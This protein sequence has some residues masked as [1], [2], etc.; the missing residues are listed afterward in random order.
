MSTYEEAAKIEFFNDCIDELAKDL[1]YEDNEISKGLATFIDEDQIRKSAWVASGLA[2]S[3]NDDHRRKALSFAILAYLK[4]S[5]EEEAEIYE[6]YLYIIL[7][8]IGDLPAVGSFVD[9]NNRTEF[10]ESLISTFDSVLSLEIESY[11]EKYG[12]GDGDYLSK[13]QNDILEALTD[14]ED[15]AISGPTSSGKSFILQEYIEEKVQKEE[16]FEVVYVVPTRALISE[17]ST[18]LKERHEEVTVK[19]GAYFNE[20]DED[21]VF[22]VVTPERC[23][24]LLRE[25]MKD[26]IDPSLL[27]FDEFQNVEDGER[28]VLYENIIQSLKE[29]WPET[30]IVVAG[31]YLDRPG[32][33]LETITGGY[34]EEITTVFTPILQLKVVLRF[35]NLGNTS[36]RRID[37]TILSPTG[38]EVS[39]QIDEPDGMMYS[40]F[41]SSKKAF[42]RRAVNE[43]GK[44]DLN[45]IYASQKGWAE[46]CAEEI[47]DGSDRIVTSEQARD[48]I[49]FL[50]RTIHEDY[51]LISCLRH[52]VAF[53]HGMV[54]KIART[55]IED[56][57]GKD[58]HT[59]I[60][61]PT[62]LQG[63]NLPAENIFIHNPYKGQ[64]QLT[65]FDFSNLIGRVGRL[66]KKLYGT[67]YCIEREDEE[68]SKDKL[69]ETSNKEIEP[70]TE[71]AL[72]RDVDDFVDVVDE[73]NIYEVEEDHLRYTGILLRNKFLKDQDSGFEEYL[74]NKEVSDEDISE[75][76]SKLSDRLDEVTVP[77]EILRRNPT[78]DP[79]QQD[80]LYK[81][82]KQN[83]GKWII[84]SHR[85]DYSYD[86]LERITE[87]LDDIFLIFD[88][89]GEQGYSPSEGEIIYTA[90]RWLSGDSYKDMIDGRQESDKIPE[91][92]DDVDI[93]IR[94]V[95]EIINKYVRF[96][97]VK[98]Y[99]ILTD[100][101]E[102]IDFETNEWMVGF[103]QMLEMGSVDFR[104]LELMSMGADRTVVVELPIPDQV[105]DVISYLEQ[106]QGRL[107]SFH[108][109]HLQEQDIL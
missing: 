20:D 64:E 8:R 27:F 25:E 60:S 26:E 65:E 29:M 79:L 21:H 61:T 86:Q 58:L 68:W 6:R 14:G 70:A 24:K 82:V 55:E 57:Y 32:E 40:D 81:S 101:L 103:D 28:G 105:D 50:G 34:V 102:E 80:K 43:F 35:R 104:K 30:Q 9:D 33:K 98:Y 71:K 53:H 56:L 74:L 3:P 49:D 4:Y 87:Q 38:R 51:S 7:S 72:Q 39:F 31:P 16:D 44:G 93:S 1:F 23:L 67:V 52:G 91:G 69:E 109:N 46:D 92:E 88:D 73:E 12:F 15:V 76:S 11:R 10:E 17:V 37:A 59:I 99:R 2:S 75:I 106:E 5:G 84:S 85:R 45:L 97:L 78:V 89:D 83:P 108:R 96:T 77:E 18:K 63:V 47:R 107:R 22:L 100:I 94:R 66:N 48:L 54:P 13:F 42:L 95:M 62:L 90:H 41:G 19:T 36:H